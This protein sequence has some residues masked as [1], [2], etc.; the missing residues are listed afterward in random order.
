V[1]REARPDEAELVAGIQRDSA[2]AAFAHIFPPDRYPFPIEAVTQRWIQ[3]LTDPRMRVLVAEKNGAAVGA[4]GY[5]SEW[6]DGLYVVPA[7]WGR[8]VGAELHDHVLE[9]LLARG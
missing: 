7:F 5:R 6:L 8:G 3:A 4:A 2:V 9:Q 1:I